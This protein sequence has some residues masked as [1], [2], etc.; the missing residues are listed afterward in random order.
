M[1]GIRIRHVAA[2]NSVYLVPIMAKPFRDHSLNNEPCPSCHLIHPCKTVHLW[3]DG[4]GSCIVSQGVLA[5][6]QSAGMPDLLVEAEVVNPPA[7][8]FGPGVTRE[9]IDNDNRRIVRHTP[10][11]I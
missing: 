9:Q 6:L 11:H 8:H 10:I 5:D 4:N 3:L 1:P 2:K 7:L